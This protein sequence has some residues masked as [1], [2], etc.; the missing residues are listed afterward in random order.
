M[1]HDRIE[2]QLKKKLYDLD[3]DPPVDLWARIEQDLKSD[4]LIV[5][6]L[7]QPAKPTLLRRIA[8]FAAASI[9]IGALMIYAASLINNPMQLGS[10]VQL[11]EVQE[12][13]QDANE[14]D[15][16][17]L[18][19]SQEDELPLLASNYETEAQSSKGE[20]SKTMVMSS[21]VEV[22]GQETDANND[23]QNL[24]DTYVDEPQIEAEQP[25]KEGWEQD[26]DVQA[27]ES[28][29]HSIPDAT[30]QMVIN[31]SLIDQNSFN[32]PKTTLAVFASPAYA[33][34]ASAQRGTL[35]A[36]RQSMASTSTESITRAPSN[37]P[38]QSYSPRDFKHKLPLTVGVSL[39]W[40][41]YKSLRLETGLVYNY[42]VSESSS[43]SGVF[44]YQHRQELHY[45]GIP[46]SMQYTFLQY[47]SLS[48]YSNLGVMVEKGLSGTLS[49]TIEKEGSATVNDSSKISFKSVLP[50]INA[51]LGLEVR[52]FDMLG[53]YLEPTL[54]YYMNTN[55]QPASYRTENHFNFSLTTGL[56]VRFK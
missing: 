35:S 27:M 16:E 36:S 39:S 24:Q 6:S 55:Y 29:E 56:R 37:I 5:A 13:V 22:S 1:K 26:Y 17:L 53:I 14:A 49:S 48:I 50:S 34:V 38:N 4:E 40:H 15:S 42:L 19:V 8:P 18:A 9:I 45:L 30:T 21:Q 10:S 47:K 11:S 52:L 28:T 46:V 44:S 20:S 32:Q 33:Q 3:Q 51:G 23:I 2:Q 7:Q 43:Q 31:N 54:N 41:I 12:D 25:E